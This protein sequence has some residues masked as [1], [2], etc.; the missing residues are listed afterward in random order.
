MVLL[1]REG[2]EAQ[3]AER[4]GDKGGDREQGEGREDAGNER[5]E[6]PDRQSAGRRLGTLT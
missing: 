1:E 4:T 5:E 3:F 6:E 2:L